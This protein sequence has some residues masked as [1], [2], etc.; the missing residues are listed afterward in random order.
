[1]MQETTYGDGRRLEFLRRVIEVARP[2]LVLDIGCGTGMRVTR[3]LAEDFPTIR[4]VGTDPDR[5]SIAWANDN[6]RDLENLSFVCL[7]N[8]LPDER[9]DLV[10]ASEVIEHVAEPVKF[11]RDIHGRLSEKGRIVL[12]LP[13]G[14]GPFEFMALIECVL[15]MSGIQM[16]LR[17]LKYLL[18]G[19]SI[20]V[21]PENRDTL[22]ISPHVN[23]FSFREIVCLF[24]EAG[25]R[26]AQ[27]VNRSILCGYILDDLI[28]SPHLIA[29]NARLADHMPTWCVS[30]WMFELE[31]VRPSSPSHWRRGIWA[32]FRKW[33]NERRWR[34]A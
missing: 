11:L 4:F 3:P 19:R 30:D 29:L 5:T 27:A 9:F 16:V 32:R 25:F 10:I 15:H 22:A 1:M 21:A 28:S 13:N 7:G 24:N 31:P 2:R 18:R 34:Q 23:F 17:R 12:T 6:N 26:V 8:A 33:L 14:Y 20:A